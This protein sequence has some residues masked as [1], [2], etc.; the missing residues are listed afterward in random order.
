MQMCGDRWA[1]VGEDASLPWAKVPGLLESSCGAGLE[2]KCQRVFRGEVEAQRQNSLCH[3]S[4]VGRA[5]PMPQLDTVSSQSL[6][7]P[8]GQCPQIS[9]SVR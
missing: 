9:E 5:C 7:P 8:Q 4:P 3:P 1:D 6:P 2:P